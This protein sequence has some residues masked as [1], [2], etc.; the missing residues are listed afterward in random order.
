MFGKPNRRTTVQ[1]YVGL[2]VSLEETSVCVMDRDGRILQ[3]GITASEP[4]M[5]AAYVRRHA[6]DA[7]RIVLETGQLSIWLTRELLALGLPAV[8]VD[9]RLA[10][11]ALS[12]RRNKSDRHDAEGLAHL[13]RTGWFTEVQIKSRSSDERRTLLGARDRMI[14]IRKD[15]EGQVRGVLKIFGIKLGKIAPGKERIG[16]R[17][18]VNEVIANEPTIKPALKALLTVHATTCKEEDRLDAL[19]RRRAKSDKTARL[20]MTAPGVGAIVAS[21][22]IAIIDDPHRFR[23]SS[24]AGAY[25]GLTPRRY[26]SGEI[27]YSGKISKWG[28][29]MLRAYLYE[30]AVT[31]L[32]R[33]TRSSPLK[34]W[35]LRLWQQKG[36][37]KAAVAVARKLA[38]IL[39]C[40]WRDNITF[41]WTKEAKMAA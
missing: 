18:R 29:P 40:M 39:L 23:R 36:F 25:I 1:Q 35:G 17:Q 5:I 21:A 8:C 14:R 24:Q 41:Q 6:P 16:F 13:A 33:G 11:K 34:S 37:T 10:H 27:D 32:T 3:R 9:A 20:L 4:A 31:L 12:G 22:F 19:I 15:L 7:H 30:A 2:D 38:N 28:D 26:Q